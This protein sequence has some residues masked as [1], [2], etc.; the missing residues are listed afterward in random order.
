[1]CCGRMPGLRRAGLPESF[2]LLKQLRMSPLPTA[3]VRMFPLAVTFLVPQKMNTG[4]PG[5]CNSR[6][7]NVSTTIF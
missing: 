5:D 6:G 2:N 7:C 3:Q 1:M 4:R